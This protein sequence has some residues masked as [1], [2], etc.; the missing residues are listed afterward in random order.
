MSEELND[1]LVAGENVQPVTTDTDADNAVNSESKATPKTP[2]VEYKDG[3][4]YS[5]D[6][7]RV[8]TRDD[9]NRIGANAK[10]ETESRILGELEVDSFDQVKTVVKQLRSVS[11]EEPTLNVASLRDAVKKKEQTVEELRAELQRVKTDMVLKDHLV[12]LNTAMPATWTQEQRSAV[13]DLMKARNMLHLEGE[14]F[15]IR[16]GDSFFTDASGEQPDYAAAVTSIGRTLGLPITKQGVAIFDTPDKVFDDVKAI[17]GLDAKRMQNDA[18]YRNAYVQVRSRDKNLAHSDVT[19]AMV[20]KQLDG[21]TRGSASD[22][23]LLNT[24]N[25]SASKS[26][27]RR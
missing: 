9:V 27:S 8:Y 6:G 16:N 24:G 10:K 15:A 4:V 20:R 19:D 21:F 12:N 25:T 23:M 18:A 11:D 13:V 7:V 3:K 2:A 1:T 5:I 14:T 22:R 26:N 17:K